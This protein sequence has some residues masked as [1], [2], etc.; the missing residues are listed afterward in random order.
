[1]EQLVMKGLALVEYPKTIVYGMEG[2]IES[3][4][5][6]DNS[7][8]ALGYSVFYYAKTM[9]NRDTIKLI[10]INGIAP[11]NKSIASGKQLAIRLCS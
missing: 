9:Y 8:K 11:D 3:I 6:Y 1:M 2:L 7:E 4:A 10:S 5:K